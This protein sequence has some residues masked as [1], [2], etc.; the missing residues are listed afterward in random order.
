MLTKKYILDEKNISMDE[1]D[2]I[3]MLILKKPE[4][5]GIFLEYAKRYAGRELEEVMEFLEFKAFFREKNK[6]VIQEDFYNEMCLQI[7]NPLIFHG[8]EPT[9]HSKE[10]SFIEFTNI[11]F[12]DWNLAINP[13][14]VMKGSQE[15]TNPATAYFINTSHN[16]FVMDDRQVGG[17]TSC[18]AYYEALQLGCRSIEIDCW[19][20]HDGMPIVTNE[21]DKSSVLHL[22]HVLHCISKWA[23]KYADTPLILCFDNHC[24]IEQ[25]KVIRRL[26]DEYFSESLYY[27][28][29]TEFKH[30][31]CPTP[32][33][34]KKK[35]LIKSSSI[36]RHKA[37]TAKVG[38]RNKDFVP[39][40][41]GAKARMLR[42]AM[43]DE[44]K[45]IKKEDAKKLKE[46]EKKKKK[47]KDWIRQQ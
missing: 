2:I 38:A 27:I 39:L 19:D 11:L 7:K 30:A 29:E 12:S 15:M 35:I 17:A 5:R 1:I 43:A 44:E 28:S 20:G 24:S 4:F 18:R 6:E 21:G 41:G 42:E 26:L 37:V 9:V 16:T 14:N 32:D 22:D 10:L 13:K 45:L 3:C 36:Y 47:D 40:E 46:E 34:M 8:V 33:K 31:Y 25:R 23:F